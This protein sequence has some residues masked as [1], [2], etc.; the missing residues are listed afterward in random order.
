MPRQLTTT[1][2]SH[3]EWTHIF[4]VSIVIIPTHL[5][6]QMQANSSGAEFLSTISKF[7]KRKK[8]LSLLVHVLH[9]M[10]NWAFSRGSRAVMAK[11]YTKKRDARAKLFCLVKLLVF[12]LSCRPFILNFLLSMIHCDP[13]ETIF[14]VQI[15][16]LLLV[17]SEAFFDS[18]VVPLLLVRKAWW[19]NRTIVARY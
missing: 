6:C 7:I 3:E 10:W 8:I 2:T 17:A 18:S 12:L 19:T 5:L 9:K 15:K 13:S 11:K 4:S 16:L 1:K 14:S